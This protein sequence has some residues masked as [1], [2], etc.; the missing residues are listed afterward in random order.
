MSFD[1]KA[2]WN[3][4]YGLY[5]ITSCDGKRKNGQIANTVIQVTANPP[6]IAVSIN[7][8][9]YTHEIISKG[10]SFAVSILEKETPMEFIGLFGFKSGKEIDKFDGKAITMG[11]TGCPIVKDYSLASINVKVCNVVDVGS[12]TVFIGDVVSGKVLKQGE[13][14]TYAYYQNVKKGK[15]HKNAPTYKDPGKI[16]AEKKEGEGMQKYVCKVC[17][18][19]YDPEKGDPENGVNPGTKFEDVPEDWL[20]PVCGVGKDQF[21]PEA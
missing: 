15:A 18:Y 8:N 12:H 13:P 7:K 11:E 14:L 16:T 21:E 9:C 19:V 10:K 17:G 5:L 20:C 2:L 3:I 4:T 1:E 6:R